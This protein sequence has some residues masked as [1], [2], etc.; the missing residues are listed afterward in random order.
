MINITSENPSY[1]DHFERKPQDNISPYNWSFEQPEEELTPITKSDC[2]KLHSEF[3]RHH[4][5]TKAINEHIAAMLEKLH[6]KSNKK[7]EKQ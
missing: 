6:D 4:S 5:E 3:D 7:I 2:E 1:E